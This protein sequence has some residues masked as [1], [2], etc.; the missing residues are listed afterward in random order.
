[1]KLLPDELKAALPPLY[2]NEEIKDPLVRLKFFTPDGGWTWFVTEGQAEG[3]DFLFFGFVVGHFPE[4]GYFLLSE[5][6]S[7]HGVLGLS[8]E[9][10]LHFTPKPFSQLQPWERGE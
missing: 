6:E 7:I 1:M 9:R 5:L 10:D 8:V 3:Q 4:W 2:S